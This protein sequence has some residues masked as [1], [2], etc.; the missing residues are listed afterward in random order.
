VICLIVV[1]DGLVTITLIDVTVE[2]Y[3]CISLRV[4]FYIKFIRIN[5]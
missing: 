1:A 4:L 3:V 5:M 2:K